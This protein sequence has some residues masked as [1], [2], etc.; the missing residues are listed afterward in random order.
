VLTVRGA[1]AGEHRL[2]A[3]SLYAGTPDEYLSYLDRLPGLGLLSGFLC[4]GLALLLV[5]AGGVLRLVG[6]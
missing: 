2:L 6:G 5:M 3:D 4:G 1:T